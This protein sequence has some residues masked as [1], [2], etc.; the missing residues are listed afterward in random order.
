M[1]K[2][3]DPVQGRDASYRGSEICGTLTWACARRP[4]SSPGCH[5]AG[6]QLSRMSRALNRAIPPC[7]WH[8]IVTPRPPA[9]AR[10]RRAGTAPRLKA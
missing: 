1:A 2:L 4:H 9:W 6:F 5:I 8:P 3:T 10:M 7:S